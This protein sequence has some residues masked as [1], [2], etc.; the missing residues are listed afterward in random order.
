[1]LAKVED[2]KKIKSLDPLITG[3]GKSSFSI[4][5]AEEIEFSVS[6]RDICYL[7]VDKGPIMH[8]FPTFS[9]E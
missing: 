9:Q 1:M 6:T 3:L 2:F 4:P 7:F 8:I 5:K